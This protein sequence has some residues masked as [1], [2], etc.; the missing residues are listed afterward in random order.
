M[1]CGELIQGLRYLPC[2]LLNTVQ[3]PTTP[4]TARSIARGTEVCA[5]CLVAWYPAATIELA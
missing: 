1:H 2:R 4:N 3:S 5:M